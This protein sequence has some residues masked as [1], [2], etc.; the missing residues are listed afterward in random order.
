MGK[1]FQFARRH[2]LCLATHATRFHF[3]RM[4][5][6]F[7]LLFLSEFHLLFCFDLI[8][9]FFNVLEAA[10]STLATEFLS[11]TRTFYGEEKAS[12]GAKDTGEDGFVSERSQSFTTKG[13]WREPYS[14]FP[15]PS[16]YVKSP[17]SIRRALDAIAL[18]NH[19]LS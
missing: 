8:H 15:V 11:G 16:V 9:T 12:I 2:S 7:E 13:Y 10:T 14:S 1:F 19:L 4:L 17:W 3:R 5:L 6:C 18:L